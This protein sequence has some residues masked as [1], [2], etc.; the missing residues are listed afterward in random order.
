[1]IKLVEV[2]KINDFNPHSKKATVRYELAEIWINPTSILQI[3]GDT[4]MKYNLVQGYLP[5]N[6]DKRQ[7]FSYIQ[8]GSGNNITGV[9][10]VGEPETITDKIHTTA[11]RTQQLL[12]G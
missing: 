5:E 4:A 1:M 10:V 12:K 2:K 8:F 9:T 7:K 11:K 6:L 3:K